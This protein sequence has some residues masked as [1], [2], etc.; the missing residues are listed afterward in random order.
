[1]SA[2]PQGRT[3]GGRIAACR[4][5]ARIQTDCLASAASL[6]LSKLEGIEAGTTRPDIA[7]VFR[8]TKALELDTAELI[9]HV[10]TPDADND[11]LIA[12]SRNIMLL[13]AARS[14]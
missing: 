6:P 3:I 5:R 12:L 10:P 2:D 11:P 14:R 13:G 7:V 8:V 1:M 9:T 4:R